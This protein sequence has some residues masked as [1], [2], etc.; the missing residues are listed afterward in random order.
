VRQNLVHRQMREDILARF[1][2]A[3]VCVPSDPDV[4][5]LATFVTAASRPHLK[6]ET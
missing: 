5:H 3:A 6:L 4:S 2:R 1:Q